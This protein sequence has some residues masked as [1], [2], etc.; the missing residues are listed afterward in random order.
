MLP[1]SSS[2][3]REEIGGAKAILEKWEKKLE[4]GLP[5]TEQPGSQESLESFIRE[6]CGELVICAGKCE[7]IVGLFE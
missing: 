5:M 2:L 4:A 1:I 7:N 3:L 6:M